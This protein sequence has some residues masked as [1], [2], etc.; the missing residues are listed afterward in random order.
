[1]RIEDLLPDPLPVDDLLTEIVRDTVPDPVPDREVVWVLVPDPVAVPERLVLTVAV[2][3][4]VDVELLDTLADPVVVRVA[5]LEEVTDTDAETDRVPRLLTVVEEEPV[6]VHERKGVGVH[7]G[8]NEDEAEEETLFDTC[9]LAVPVRVVVILIDDVEVPVLLGD[10]GCPFVLVAVLEEVRLDDIERVPEPVAEELLVAL[11]LTELVAVPFTLTLAV[12]VALVDLVVT[13]VRVAKE[14]AVPDRDG[15]PDHV[16]LDDAVGVLLGGAD[17]VRRALA[18]EV[19]VCDTVSDAVDVPET[20]FV[21]AEVLDIDAVAEELR[22]SRG[23]VVL[24]AD[25]EEVL[26][27]EAD[28]VVERVDVTVRVD[29]EDVVEVRDE[30]VVL[31][32]SAVAE[33]VFEI[34]PVRVDV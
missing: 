20:V 16:E 19:F 4:T 15:F 26:D 34:A 7:L 23:L 33:L 1:V 10:G 2:P 30:V 12:V 27:V 31:E 21:P 18:L 3:V 28:G 5:V 8:V 17:T 13:E 32:S 22:E 11:P 9:A 24:I 29:V 25:A 6:P 14:E